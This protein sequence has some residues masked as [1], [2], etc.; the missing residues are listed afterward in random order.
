MSLS[1]F[2]SVLFLATIS[3]LPV[4][5]TGPCPPTPCKLFSCDPLMLSLTS[6]TAHLWLHL[7]ILVFPKKLRAPKG[8]RIVISFWVAS[9]SMKFYQLPLGVIK[10]I[11]GCEFSMAHRVPFYFHS[12]WKWV[13]WKKGNQVKLRSQG[14]WDWERESNSQPSPQDSGTWR[15]EEC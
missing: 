10:A 11:Q 7:S 5:W 13:R 1:Y 14:W 3:V 8:H 4:I 12:L 2:P 9:V 15:T 6:I